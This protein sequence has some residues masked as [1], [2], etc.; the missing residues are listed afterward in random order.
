VDIILAPDPV[1][2]EYTVDV[3]RIWADVLFFDNV[4]VAGPKSP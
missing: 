4:P 1:A 2:A 3:K